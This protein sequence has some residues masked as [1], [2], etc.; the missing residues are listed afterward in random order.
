[1]ADSDAVTVIVSL[2]IIFF[3]LRYLLD[4]E[5]DVIDSSINVSVTLLKPPLTTQLAHTGGPTPPSTSNPSR[6][7]GA[8]VNGVRPAAGRPRRLH[9][10]SPAQ[11]DTVLGMFPHFPR[12]VIEADLAAT[13][14]VEATCENILTGLLVPPPPPPTPSPA[15]SATPSHAS[16]SLS[17]LVAKVA[18]SPPTA[19]SIPKKVWEATPEAREANLKARKE[20][21]VKQAREKLKKQAEERAKAASALAGGSGVVEER[22]F[23]EDEYM[24]DINIHLA[25]YSI[26][27]FPTALDVNMVVSCP[28]NPFSKFPPEVQ[29]GDE[30][31]TTN[32]DNQA[33]SLVSLSSYGPKHFMKP[34]RV[35][36]THSLITAYGLHRKLINEVPTYATFKQVTKF[37]AD[38][39]IDFLRRVTPENTEEIQKW[40]TKFNVGE[41]CPDCPVFDGIFEFCMLSSGGS[42]E[43]AHKLNMGECDVAINWGGGLH[44]A[45]KGEAAGFCYVNDIV[46]AILELLKY[47]QRVL[48]IDTD[49]HHGDGVE[50]A[51]YTSD[52]VM[53]LS[54]HKF[55]EFFPGTGALND[56]GVGK[57]RN[58]SVN[59]PLNDGIDDESYTDIFRLII[60]EVMAR[61]RPGAVVLQLGADSLVG[62][63]LG[64]FNLSMRGHGQSVE[65]LKSFGVPLILLGGGGYTIRNVARAW[66]YETSLAAGVELPDALP[67][68]EYFEGYGPEYCLNIPA[69]NMENMNS[70]EYIDKIKTGVLKHLR[71]IPHAPSVQLQDVPIDHFSS[72]DE[73]DDNLE[74]NPA[75]QRSSQTYH[76]SA[77]LNTNGGYGSGTSG[78]KNK[79]ARNEEKAQSM[80]YRFREA[81]AAEMG[82]GLG[83]RKGEKR[84]PASTITNPKEG[85]RWRGQI[86]REISRKI[87]KIQ[88]ESLSEYEIRDLND[89]I[90]K[91]MREKRYWEYRI[92]E[93]GGPDYRKSAGRMLDVAG[94]E[95]PGSRGYRY[96][97]RAK[98]LPGVKE[99]FAKPVHDEKNKTRAE[100]H[101]TVDA[102]YYG[103]RAEDD[104]RL[105]EY[106]EG[107]AEEQLREA[108]EAD[109]E[110]G[111]IESLDEVPKD[112]DRSGKPIEPPHIPTAADMEA[113]LVRKK[114]RELVDRT[115]QRIAA[116]RVERLALE[117]YAKGPE[118]IRWDS[119]SFN[120]VKTSRSHVRATAAKSTASC[121]RL[122]PVGPENSA[123][124][125]PVASSKTTA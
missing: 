32:A 61:F 31:R 102:D 69:S 58:Y 17:Q 14:S 109:L 113:W 28:E 66:C 79:E 3:V 111:L 65:Y 29:D 49:V 42:I 59:V 11:V 89:E 91:L 63:R 88:D 21:M 83:I 27:L 18:S 120:D 105:L 123:T 10:V 12:H 68:H 112:W 56:I 54:L 44:H 33:P 13:G 40:Q 124:V 30:E 118:K 38:D 98:D 5:A 116:D 114:K 78:V 93:L 101:K 19:E 25:R 90:N 20:M 81:Q 9:P 92:K 48:Y 4:A 41:Y 70:R 55:G 97:G 51:F 122:V 99:L 16:S 125:P 1:M 110:A 104:G 34:A 2:V 84:P 7:A 76:L 45:K 64:C 22:K 77:G 53:T 75:W 46:L 39:Y 100:M 72:D 82:L 96:F 85:D 95:I 121:P 107:I 60:D 94:Q 86:I 74:E 119:K 6:T 117:N 106:E 43:A 52:R 103:Y 37:H 8:A 35:R 50:E 47:H 115:A 80:L 26:I 24:V 36:M 23:G 108:L 73:D 62:D 71:E 67:Y 15:S 87:S 57:G